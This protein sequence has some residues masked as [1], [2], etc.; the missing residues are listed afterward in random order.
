MRDPQGLQA[1]CEG[2]RGCARGAAAPDPP[3]G[4]A[5]A[6]RA[7]HGSKVVAVAVVLRRR[8]PQGASEHRPPALHEPWPKPVAPHGAKPAAP[9]TCAT[10]AQRHTP[11]PQAHCALLSAEWLF[12]PCGGG[13]KRALLDGPY[14]GGARQARQPAAEDGPPVPVPIPVGHTH[15]PVLAHCA[16]MSPNGCT[17]RPSPSALR[18]CRPQ[19]PSWHRQRPTEEPAARPDT[20]RRRQPHI[21]PRLPPGAPPWGYWKNREPGTCAP[22]PWI[23]RGPLATPGA[24]R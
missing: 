11:H 18:L 4:R 9:E 7:P 8:R 3:S 24:R 22:K 19:P 1:T 12:M 10:R 14:P 15:A 20:A 17:P 13:A 2:K 16:V 5:A 21:F 23:H 6:W